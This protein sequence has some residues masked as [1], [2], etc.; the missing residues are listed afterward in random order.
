LG[1]KL[2]YT[3]KITENNSVGIVV[4]KDWKERLVDVKKFKPNLNFKLLVQT[5]ASILLVVMHHK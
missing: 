4:D 3:G 2:W 1:F 5:R